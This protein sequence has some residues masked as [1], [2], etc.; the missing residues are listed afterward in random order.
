MRNT[1][2]GISAG[3]HDAAATVIHEGEILFAAHAERFSQVKNDPE[4]NAELLKEAESYLH[5]FRYFESIAYYER[6]WARY[7]RQVYTGEKFI[8][9]KQDYTIKHL[10][11]GRMK[12]LPVDYHNHHQC[13]AAAAF[14]TSP[15]QEATC[16]VI[17]A[18]GEF[19]CVTIW[20]AEYDNKGV[21][22][23]EQVYSR[24]YPNSIGLL[25]SAA[26]ARVGL[27]PMDEEYILMG[28]AAYGAPLHEKEIM[29]ATDGD[30]NFNINFHAGLPDNFCEGADPFDLAASVQKVAEL[31]I[32][33][34]FSEAWLKGKTTNFCYGGGVALNCLANSL[35]QTTL[36]KGSPWASMWI[37]PNPGDA[38]A[39][40]GAAALSYGRKVNWNGPYLGTNMG[41]GFYPV[42]AI[43]D[44][45]TENKIV[46]VAHGR[47]EFGPRALGNRSLFADPRGDDIKD[48]VNAIKQRQEFRPFA[49]VIRYEDA[50]RFFSMHSD[51][52]SPYMQHVYKCFQPK[53]FPAICHE[54]LTSR[55][56]T[57]TFDQHPGLYQLL[58]AWYKKTGCPMLLNTSLNIRGMPMVNNNEHAIAFEQEY[59][60]KVIT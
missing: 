10:L 44:E 26:T 53:E 13:H 40:L 6:P 19:D 54:D 46:G 23:Y 7:M 12:K 52:E 28:M 5:K 35:I 8:P 51:R 27:R 15:F 47:A 3:T 16:V 38:G 18:I 48:K 55:V 30:G 41:E 59:N 60:V 58:T 50:H 34:V 1:V 43:I 9:S 25:Y 32:M 22:H 29:D 49:P 45:L 20:N 17:D 42:D 24:A 31:L 36:D 39:S 33:D 11:E 57:V 56:Q 37:M 14:Q 2:L 21:A 4:L